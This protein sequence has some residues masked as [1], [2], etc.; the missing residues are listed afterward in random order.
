MLGFVIRVRKE[1]HIRA[2]QPLSAAEA[3]RLCSWTTAGALAYLRDFLVFDEQ[4][5]HMEL[6]QRRHRFPNKPLM[7]WPDCDRVLIGNAHALPQYQL[8]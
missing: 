7:N 8:T 1:T 3:V 6:S 5:P 4:H 2:Q